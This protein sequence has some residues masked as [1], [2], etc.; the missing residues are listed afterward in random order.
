MAEASKN[1]PLGFLNIYKPKGMTSHDVIS[2][3]R[4]ITHIKQIG[5][6]GTLDPFAVGVLPVGI[7]KATKLFEYLDDDK[8]YLATVQF[9]KNTDTYDIE[10]EVTN[11]FD[12]KVTQSQVEVALKS[13]EGEISQM[14]PIYSA[15]KLNGKKLYEY[16]REGKDVKI[17]PRKVFIN[18]IELKEFDEENQSA[19]ILV[20]CSKGTYIRSIAYD[21]GKTLGCGGY[22]TALERTKA[23]KFEVRD[24]IELDKFSDMETVIQNLIYPTKVLDIPSYELNAQECVRVSHGM[25]LYNDKFTTG[26]IVFLVYSGRIL[27]VGKVEQNKIL[28]KKVFEVL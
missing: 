5:H 11:T 25:A 10:G 12:K 27:A 21:L 22:L 23:G 26:D 24:A 7:G 9:G 13:F 20:A 6:T 2:R 17:E 16:A 3:L 14:P 28:A 19:Q 4:R 8:E 15:I 18:K 1:L